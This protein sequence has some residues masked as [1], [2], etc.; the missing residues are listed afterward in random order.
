MLRN[1]T[2]CLNDVSF[3]YSAATAGEG[4]S[5]VSLSGYSGEVI[6][7][8]GES[9]SGKTT[10]TKL[11]NG[12][13]PHYDEGSLSGD[14]MVCGFDTSHTPLYE[15]S[16]KVGSVFQNPRS[17]FFTTDT[18]SE[19]AFSCENQGMDPDEI[20]RRV[21]TT[22]RQFEI[23]HLL[24]RS[25]FNLSGGEKQ[26]IACGSAST[27]DPQLLVLDEPSSN[28]DME[29]IGYLRQA[30]LQWKAAKKTVLL[31]EH[32]VFYVRDLVDRVVLIRKGK[33]ASE[34]SGDSFR[35]MNNAE[36]RSLGIRCATLSRDAPT[37]ERK[38]AR[39]HDIAV[40]EQAR[41]V[42]KRGQ[43]SALDIEHLELPRQGIV[44]LIGRNGAG[45][46][47]FSLCLSGLV[48]RNK[49]RVSIDGE[50]WVGKKLSKLSYLVMQ[51]VNH[52][53]FAEDVLEEVLLNMD[54]PC[55]AY[56][57]ELLQQLS[58]EGLEKR[59]P[60]SLS[61]GQ[62]QRVAIAAALAANR[63]ILIYDEPTS[64]L[65]L[66]H[67]HEVANVIKEMQQ[68]G[69]LQIIVTHDPELIEACCTHAFEMQNSHA[70]E[71][72]PLDSNGLKRAF[73]FFE[74]QPG[75]YKALPHPL[76]HLKDESRYARCNSRRDY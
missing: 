41:H 72:Y 49:T 24:N 25:I 4:I 21:Q 33:I 66:Y 7:L 43:L 71:V 12:L 30:I 47:T 53:L 32:R 57:H 28:L 3:S 9:G 10:I 46:S 61:G 15:L 23:T 73:S 52:Q 44:A 34:L 59:H 5:S 48:P 2:F 74:K 62:K 16:Q 1:K 56:A 58:L 37:G 63:K 68:R 11:L 14:V 26:R 65:D 36:L 51:D 64:G 54:T 20:R 76:C 70:S 19:L 8:V 18:A 27:I 45:K 6:L 38:L 67:M 60:L 69:L 42:Y 75:A 22:A 29:G 40:V 55:E 13:I 50:T 31:A 35:N 17:Q 39:S